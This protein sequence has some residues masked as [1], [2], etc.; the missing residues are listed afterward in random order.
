VQASGFPVPRLTLRGVLEDGR[1]SCDLPLVE[2]EKGSVGELGSARSYELL[3]SP[4]IKLACHNARNSRISQEDPTKLVRA[5]R[6]TV[7]VVESGVEARHEIIDF[8]LLIHSHA[9]LPQCTT[10]WVERLAAIC[11]IVHT[12]LYTRVPFGCSFVTRNGNLELLPNRPSTLCGI[13]FDRPVVGYGG[14]T[15]NTLRLWSARGTP[16]IFSSSAPAS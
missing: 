9:K 10:E 6:P 8:G 11:V 13:P 15:I 3:D 1:F 14:N 4:R 16:S 5:N 2:T 12:I 7:P